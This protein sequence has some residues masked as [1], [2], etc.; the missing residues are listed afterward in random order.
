MSIEKQR[1]QN[2]ERQ[3]R[4]RDKRRGTLD[5]SDYK[6]PDVQSERLRQYSDNAL[7]QMR[8]ELGGFVRNDDYIIR[9]VA[10]VV[11]ALENKWTQ[12]VLNPEGILAGN[13]FPDAIAS[14][15]IEHLRNSRLLESPAFKELYKRFIQAV[16]VFCDTEDERYVDPRYAAEVK[17]ELAASEEKEKL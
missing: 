1:K 17:A 7:E 6:M 9:G 13:F 5:E 10:C 12:A 8:A 11:L 16:A 14:E 2:R 3:Q 15:A 4:F